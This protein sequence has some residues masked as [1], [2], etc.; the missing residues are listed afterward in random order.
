MK[1]KQLTAHGA[2]KLSESHGSFW[3]KVFA[4]IR[5]AAVM[6]RDSCML[7]NGAGRK[8]YTHAPSR[9]Q[10]DALHA[11]GY[12]TKKYSFTPGMSSHEEWNLT[13]SWDIEREVVIL[14]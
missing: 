10:I 8:R 14:P 4:D 13:I 2:R 6:G 3:V 9:D 12:E 11:L 7:A 5:A 1:N